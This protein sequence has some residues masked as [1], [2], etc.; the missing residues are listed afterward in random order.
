MKIPKCFFP[1]SFLLCVFF[2]GSSGPLYADSYWVFFQPGI[3]WQPGDPVDQSV[4]DSVR[5]SGARIGTVSRYFHA[6][7]VDIDG[8]PL[9]LKQIKGAI[10][11][12]P[13]AQLTG[14]PDPV[15]A[16]PV[17]NNEAQ[18]NQEGHLFNYGTSYNQ[19]NL[20]KIPELHDRGLTGKGVVIGVLDAGFDFSRTGCLKQLNVAHT[21][22]F[23]NG[24]ESVSGDSHGTAVLGI[25]GGK[26]D[27]FYYGAA[28]GATFLLAL[29]EKSFSSFGTPADEARWV[30]G[31]E[32]CDSLGA[33]IVNSSLRYSTFKSPYESL[34]NREDMDG[35]TSLC[36]RAAEIAF[37]RGIVVVNGAGDWGYYEWR[38]LITPADAEHVIAV[39][40]LETTPDGGVKLCELSSRGPS[41]DGRIKPDVVAL[42]SGVVYP[43][44]GTESGYSTGGGS[45]S[46][47]APLISGLCALLLEAH[48][49]WTPSDVIEALKATA[50]DLGT[51]GPDNDSGWGL[52]DGLA[53]LNYTPSSKG[54]NKPVSQLIMT[55]NH[56]NPFNPSTTISFVLPSS[57]KASLAVYDV[58][59]RKVRELAVGTMTA[60]AH[61]A[62]WDGRDASGRAV[63]SGVYFARLSLDGAA[64][65]HRMTLMK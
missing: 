7:T 29:T 61:S 58:T 17:L 65:T 50:H 62:V 46:W 23:L 41:S 10:R 36:A 48:P 12:Q 35:K 51:P 9:F 43:K 22:N 6:V 34:Y 47:S 11:I 54:R 57:G 42:G 25:L 5:N 24:R 53:A 2:L 59:G 13:V 30:M 56:P 64:V 21:L 28:F 49:D 44:A 32:W 63:S 55:G 39:G 15:N 37:S 1:I 38:T 18:Q 31:L 40:S 26:S 45:T 4:I 3:G 20:L 27:G 60:G 16:K 52:P 33:R 14:I 19:L 8:S